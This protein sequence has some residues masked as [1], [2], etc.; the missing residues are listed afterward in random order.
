MPKNSR[1]KTTI[2]KHQCQKCN[3]NTF[4]SAEEYTKHVKNC[5]P[6]MKCPYWYCEKTFTNHQTLAH[7]KIHDHAKDMISCSVCDFQAPNL[8]AHMNHLY[9]V[10]KKEYKCEKCDCLFA[11]N[12]YKND[13]FASNS[14]KKLHICKICGFKSCTFNGLSNHSNLHAKPKPNDSNNDMIQVKIKSS[15]ELNLS[16]DQAMDEKIAQIAREIQEKA[17]KKDAEKN[18]SIDV[19]VYECDIC[20]FKTNSD[21]ALSI[22]LQNEHEDEIVGQEQEVNEE[23]QAM[24]TADANE[25]DFDGQ[26]SD[27]FAC[28]KCQFNTYD[29]VEYLNHLQNAHVV[30]EKQS[31]EVSNVSAEVLSSQAN[32]SHLALKEKSFYSS[33]AL[34]LSIPISKSFHCQKC[35]KDQDYLSPNSSHQQCSK[36]YLVFCTE[37]ELMKHILDKHTRILSDFKCDQCKKHFIEK[38]ELTKHQNKKKQICTMCYKTCCTA[39]DL[40]THTFEGKFV[41][42]I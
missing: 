41:I 40:D 1:K 7:H 20:N 34:N 30:V 37:E 35:G 26:I 15:G 31:E 16:S 9:V 21:I 2:I 22:H 19:E 28:D 10:H 33:T 29:D 36:C 3:L 17:T 18:T 13:H 25:M 23:V 6:S 24:E 42:V 27:S 14:G 5:V 39:E 12:G 8:G 4:K 11:N 38:K 32:L